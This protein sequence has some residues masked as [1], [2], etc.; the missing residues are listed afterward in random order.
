MNASVKIA[1]IGVGYWGPNLLRNLY[2]IP[3]ADLELVVDQAPERREFVRGSFPGVK[4]GESVD[5]VLEDA[6]IE[7]VVIA[8]PAGTHFEIAKRCLE[9]GKHLL[10]EKPL[11]TTVEEVD[12][13][14][15]I[16]KERGLVLMAGHTFIYND[17]VRYLRKLIESGDLGEIRYLYSKRL[18]LGRIRSDVDA[19]WN[20]APHD[21]SIVQYL[22]GDP[23]PERVERSGQAFV[24]PEIEDVVFVNIFYPGRTF[25]NIHVSWLDPHKIRQMTVVGTKKM[26]VYDDIADNKI[27]LY[28]KGIDVTTATPGGMD[29]DQTGSPTFAY[30]SGDLVYPK[31][32]FREPLKNELNHFLDCIL[33]G[34]TCLTGPAHARRVIEILSRA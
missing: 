23:E 24:Q 10:V 31:I 5:A 17:A 34:V 16:A 8:T 25:A 33:D 9:A 4:V 12:Q 7:A 32:N 20:L 18:N 30:R 2:Q 19:W 1:Q 6:A 26:A 28:D 11:A 3:R 29:Y 27:A 21:V 15:A 14:A 22:L 13:L